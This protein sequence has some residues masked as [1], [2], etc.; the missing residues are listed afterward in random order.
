M[1]DEKI[2]LSGYTNKRE[3]I[4]NH[5]SVVMGLRRKIVMEKEKSV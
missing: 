4:S 1:H 2:E 3:A 5:R